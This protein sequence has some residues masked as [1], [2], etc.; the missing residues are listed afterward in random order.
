MRFCLPLGRLTTVHK[1]ALCSPTLLLD[2][3]LYVVRWNDNDIETSLKGVGLLQRC[4]N[5]K[6]P[7]LR[8]DNVYFIISLS[9]F[10]L[11]EHGHFR[12]PFTWLESADSHKIADLTRVGYR[13]PVPIRQRYLCNR[14]VLE[15]NQNADFG[16]SFRCHAWAIGWNICPLFLRNG[17]KKHH[18]MKN[19]FQTEKMH[20]NSIRKTIKIHVQ[21][22]FVV[23]RVCCFHILT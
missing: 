21:Q 3:V 2:I 8:F 13:N 9:R 18:H 17:R 5:I 22:I 15:P 4:I 7:A 14:Y 11:T 12:L 20:V 19:N 23:T 6:T 16:A 1:A 10:S